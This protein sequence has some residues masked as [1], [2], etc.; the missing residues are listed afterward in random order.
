MFNIGYNRIHIPYSGRLS[1]S[2]FDLSILYQNGDYQPNKTGKQNLTHMEFNNGTLNRHQNKS[3]FIQTSQQSL[4][5]PMVLYLKMWE[6]MGMALKNL[7]DLQC[8]ASTANISQVMEPS[9]CSFGDHTFHFGC[10]SDFNFRD[11]FDINYWN[12]MS[13]IQNNSILV[14]NSYLQNASKEVIYVQLKYIEL[15]SW[16]KCNSLDELASEY[17]FRFFKRNGCNIS[18]VCIEFPISDSAFQNKIFGSTDAS[19]QNKTVIF[20]EWRGFKTSGHY[21][22]EVI[23]IRCGKGPATTGLVINRPP[24]IEYLHFVYLHY[25]PA[26]D[27]LAISIDFYLSTCM[28]SNMLL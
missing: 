12:Q 16:F 5:Q 24:A 8:W 1:K 7:F 26:N 28:V 3:Q 23:G 14:S 13:L 19:Q 17:W 21:R 11:F 10:Q 22:A 27:F 9:I 4:N 15:H 18:T 20:E 6:Q 25:F 2:G